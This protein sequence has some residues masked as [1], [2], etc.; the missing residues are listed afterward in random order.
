MQLKIYSIRDSKSE[1]FTQPFFQHTAGE[2]ERNFKT[3]VNDE[4]STQNKYPEDFSLWEIG[5]YDDNTGKITPIEP[6]H[7]VN[8]VQLIQKVQ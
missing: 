7:V 8:A 5:N 1:C 4:K 2:A 6:H 3:L